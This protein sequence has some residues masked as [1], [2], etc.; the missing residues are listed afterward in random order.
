MRTAYRDDRARTLVH[1]A[2]AARWRQDSSLRAYDAVVRQRISAG[3]NFKAF[4]RDRLLFRTETAARVRWVRG[5]GTRVDVLGTR[6]AVPLAFQG[7]RALVGMTAMT[8]IPYYPGREGL[9]W[10]ANYSDGDDDEAGVFIHPLDDDAERYYQF[11][12]G[13]SVTLSLPDGTSIHDAII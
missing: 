4:G 6:S 1:L 13:D 2:R 5:G 7:A 12:A 11:A 8:P 3:L 10:F 9:L